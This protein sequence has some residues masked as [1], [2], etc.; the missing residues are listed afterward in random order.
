MPSTRESITS[1]SQFDYDLNFLMDFYDPTVIYG[2]KTL[3]F[4]FLLHFTEKAHN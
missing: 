1:N 4:W 2:M 3:W